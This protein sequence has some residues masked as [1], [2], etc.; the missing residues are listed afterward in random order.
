MRAIDRNKPM[1]VGDVKVSVTPMVKLEV[2]LPRVEV[3]GKN[4]YTVI[5]KVDDNTSVDKK[6]DAGLYFTTNGVGYYYHRERPAI[7][8]TEKVRVTDINLGIKSPGSK[9]RSNPTK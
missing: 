8:S 1:T 4:F 9:S 2:G 5:K 6:P 7:G 3:E